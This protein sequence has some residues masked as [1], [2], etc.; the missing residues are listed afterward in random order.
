MLALAAG[1]DAGQRQRSP[2]SSNGGGQ[3]RS[4]A[5][6]QPRGGDRQGGGQGRQAARAPRAEGAPRTERAQPARRGSQADGAAQGARAAQAERQRPAR[7]QAVP[8]RSDAQPDPIARP[9]GDAQPDPIARPFGGGTPDPI[10][11]PF[12]EGR[13]GQ[14]RARSPYRGSAVA[15]GRGPAV[16]NSRGPAVNSRGPAVDN[17]GTRRAVPRPR[18]TP[19]RDYGY[20]GNTR[21]RGYARGYDPWYFYGY[22]RSYFYRPYAYGYGP[23]GRGWFYFDLHYNG[24]VWYPP[25]VVRYGSYGSF[26]YPTGELRLKVR[27][28]E[29]QVFVDG[30]YAGTVDSFDGV[31]QSLRLETGDYRI[32]IVLPGYEPLDVDVQIVPGQKV[33]VEADLVPELP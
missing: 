20:K 31:F 18:P 8:R 26:G 21:Y 29:A 13:Q 3:G 24:Y 27:P 5:G 23:A 2:G 14:T 9:F 15:N 25:T 7:P 16:D 11:R 6:A 4:Q 10:A 32:Q 33:T 22:P 1:S 28:R 17:G 19:R 30:Y 12:E